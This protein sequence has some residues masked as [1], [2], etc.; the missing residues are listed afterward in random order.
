MKTIT[1]STAN[2]KK[3]I[4]AIQS[5]VGAIADGMIGTQTISDLA[6]LV[7][8][9]CFPLT[10]QIYS[11]PVII[12]KDVTPFAPGTALKNWSN[13]ISGSFSANGKPCSILVQDGV[14]RQQYACH[15]IPYLKPESVL[16]RLQDGTV[17]VKRVV[18]TDELPDG[19]VWA[20]GGFGL[21][22]NYDPEAEGFCKLTHGGK[23]E[24]FSDVLRKTNHTIIGEKG[25][26]IYL[27]YCKNMTA[28]GVNSYAKKLGLS[29]AIMLDGGHVAAINGTESF[30]KINTSLKQAYV[31]Q[32]VTK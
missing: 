21:L 3:M 28:S 10:L 15:A 29:K 5:A 23:T 25:G 2:E 22:D 11:Q 26:Y 20:V 18:T 16:Y 4:R 27:A 13:S 8:A 30:T 17:D 31:V 6:R 12:A 24:N 1:G 14:I 7:E 32:G 19:V 9:D